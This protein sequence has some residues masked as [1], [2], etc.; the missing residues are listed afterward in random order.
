MI[1]IVPLYVYC[2]VLLFMIVTL[3][4][5]GRFPPSTIVTLTV[6]GRF[7]LNMIVPLTVN[8]RFP[9]NM[10]EPL[11]VNGRF[12]L[13]TIIP[14]T[15]DVECRLCKCYQHKF[16]YDRNIN[17]GKDQNS[18]KSGTKITLTVGNINFFLPVARTY[19]FV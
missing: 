9:L 4:V 12:L 14:L 2:R 7:P 17:C 18:L 5:E 1:M 8:G 3:T 13:N 6:N 16:W 19:H 11:T 15:V 10:I